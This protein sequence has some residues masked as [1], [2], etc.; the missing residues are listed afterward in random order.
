VLNSV[1]IQAGETDRVFMSQSLKA[2]ELL[3]KN[4][5]QII[6][7]KDETIKLLLTAWL[8]GGHLLIE[9]N[10]GTGKTL[11]AKTVAKSVGAEF[12]RVQFTPDLLPSDITGTT[13]YDEQSRQFQFSR[14]P[15]FSTILLADEI[16]RATPRTQAALLEAMA[17]GQVTVDKESYKLHPEFFVVA[18]QNPVEQHG[19]FPLPEAQLDRFTMKISMGYP[20]RESEMNILLGRMTSD[21]FQKLQSVLKIEHIT[22]IKKAVSEVKLSEATLK[23]ILDVVEKTRSHPDLSLPASPRASL[24]LMKT[25]QAWSFLSGEDFVRPGTIYKL[26][27]PVIEHRISQT[28]ES[29]FQGKKKSEILKEILDKV[30]VPTK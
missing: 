24:S 4:I 2:S 8:S 13:I 27:Q 21:P 1:Y 11:L 23:Y 28:K 18:T 6:H 14:G 26:L 25:S 29:K 3:L 12:G 20:S 16:N 10:P 9:D 5:S 19:T 22:E 30:K 7:G 15:I 17:E